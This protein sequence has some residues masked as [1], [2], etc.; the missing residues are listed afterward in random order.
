MA[1]KYMENEWKMNG[2]N[3]AYYVIRIRESNFQRKIKNDFQ[4]C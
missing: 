4:V 2:K 1:G 3:D